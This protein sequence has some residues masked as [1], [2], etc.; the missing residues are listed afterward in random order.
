M[1][2]FSFP[3]EKTMKFQR[4]LLVAWLT[5][6][7]TLTG[8]FTSSPVKQNNTTAIK[9][10]YIPI[11]DCLPLYVANDKGFFTKQGLTAELVPLQGGPRVIEAL[12]SKGVDFG[13]SNVVSVIV[14]HSKGIP[15]VGVTGGPI[16]TETRQA[17]AL[18]VSESSTIKT[19][20]DLAGKTVAINALR[21]LEHVVLRGYLQKNGVDPDSVKI[22]EA[23]VP[24]MEGAL[25][26]GSVD[27][28][29]PAEPFI[30]LALSHKTARIL[31]HPHTEMRPRIIIAN[32]NVRQDWLDQ[33]AETVRK[34]AAALAEANAFIA[35]NDAEAR[36]ILLK[37]T[38]I[39][40]DVIGQVVLPESVDRFDVADLQFWV[41]ELARQGIIEKT[42]PAENV[43]KQQ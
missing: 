25:K 5:I 17:H 9:I 7:I 18:M 22:V 3:K 37:Y 28:I 30:T 27:A 26:N 34:F 40:Q 33:N 32:Y 23:P 35:K 10:G 12:T 13:Y 29:Q 11:V 16:E 38:Q 6:A 39:P 8:C 41:D 15:I 21:G 2:R 43:L 42:F 31:G 20:K 4:L 1:M 19:P 24:Q 36:Q 14:A